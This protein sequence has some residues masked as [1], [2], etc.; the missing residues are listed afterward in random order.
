MNL[1]L[2]GP[3]GIGKGTQSVLLCDRLGLTHVSTGDLLR[4]ALRSENE[5][6]REAKRY[7]EAGQLVPGPVVRRLAEDRLSELGVEDFVLDGYPRTI[8]QAEWLTD[9]LER[10]ATV[11]DAVISLRGA[12]D[13]IVER[14]SQRRLDPVTGQTFHLL[15]NPPP[16]D[17]P[18]DRLVQRD[19]DTPAV[20]RERLVVYAN[21]TAPVEAY[22]AARGRHFVVDGVGEV[23]E[24]YGRILDVLRTVAPDPGEA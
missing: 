18:L 11:L 3:P 5:V 12:E 23:E 16:P 24:V 2:F 8:E 19:D 20:I 9:F 17:V 13:V 7:I 21:E 4:A 15:Y 6:G 1:V 22:Y 10:H 14:L